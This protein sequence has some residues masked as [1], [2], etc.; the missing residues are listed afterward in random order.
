MHR[1]NLAMLTAI[2]GGRVIDPGHL[3]TAADI[4]IK[5]NKIV[6]IIT[7]GQQEAIEPVSR[8]IDASGK[9]V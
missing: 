1:E 2:Q 8:I 9:I 4:L 3:D 7:E 5:D 6:Q